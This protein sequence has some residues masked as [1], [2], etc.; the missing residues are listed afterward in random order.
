VSAQTNRT[1]RPT[2]SGLERASPLSGI[3]CVAFSYRDTLEDLTAPMVDG[4]RAMA[5]DCV[6]VLRTLADHHL[7]LML[8]ADNKPGDHIWPALNAAGVDH[9]FRVRLTSAAL[10]IEKDD[11]AWWRGLVAYSGCAAWCVLHVGADIETDVIAPARCGLRVALVRHNG[12]SDYEQARLPGGALVINHL[13]DLLPLLVSDTA[14]AHEPGN[15]PVTR[16][17]AGRKQTENNRPH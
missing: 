10:G 9:L 4:T 16:Y 13:R 12:A 15:S 2:L 7:R 14:P 8:S 6:S 3:G 1:D 11:P 17:Y 5:A